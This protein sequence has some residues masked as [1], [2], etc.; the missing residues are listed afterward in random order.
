MLD[1]YGSEAIGFPQGWE[2][3]RPQSSNDNGADSTENDRWHGSEPMR[4][5]TGLELPQFVGGTNEDHVNCVDA[6]AHFV[7]R[8]NLYQRGP[9]DDADHVRRAHEDERDQRKDHAVGDTEQNRADTEAGDAPQHGLAYA[10][11]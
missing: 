6:A 7:G 2:H 9:D 5:D 1:L 10:A 4:G 3:P 11:L 8:G